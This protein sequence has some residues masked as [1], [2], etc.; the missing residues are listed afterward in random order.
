M[1]LI[2]QG[3]MYNIEVMFYLR[4]TSYHKDRFQYDS[5]QSSV[6]NRIGVDGLNIWRSSTHTDPYTRRMI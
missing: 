1:L 3:A 4:A 6:F 2:K 5:V